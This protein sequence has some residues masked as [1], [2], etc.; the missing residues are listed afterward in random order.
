[1][2]VSHVWQKSRNFENAKR[3]IENKTILDRE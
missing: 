3:L 1:M 2:P